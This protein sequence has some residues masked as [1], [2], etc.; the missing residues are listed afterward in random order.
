MLKIFRLVILTMSPILFG[1]AWYVLPELLEP[2]ALKWLSG[3]FAFAWTIEFV[4][5]R[6]VDGL[7]TSVSSL[8]SREHE[9]L[10]YR[11]VVIRGRIFWMAGIGLAC[12]I[13]AWLLAVLNLPATSV[14]YAAAF[15]FLLGVCLSYLVLMPYWYKEVQHFLESIRLQADIETRRKAALK[16][17]R[18]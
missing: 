3:I 11:L 17:L 1:L 18:G 9:R 2:G 14:L 5:L 10:G 12:T 6:M 15:G 4:V 8:S 13:V 16:D 7:H